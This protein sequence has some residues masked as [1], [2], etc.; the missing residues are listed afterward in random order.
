MEK[1]KTLKTKCGNIKRL[2]K[3]PSSVPNKK[4]PVNIKM[5]SLIKV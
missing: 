5:S 3:K 4:K 1:T 2:H